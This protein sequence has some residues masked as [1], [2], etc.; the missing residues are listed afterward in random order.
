M[1]FFTLK[2]ETWKEDLKAE[3]EKNIKRKRKR[4][5][6]EI[7]EF[8]KNISSFIKSNDILNERDQ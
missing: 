8:R 1:Y 7:K 3:Q 6:E 4:F 2:P 5:N